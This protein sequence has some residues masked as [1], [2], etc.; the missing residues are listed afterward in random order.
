M[1][2]N[3]EIEVLGNTAPL[4]PI[5]DAPPAE[6]APTEAP[7]ENVQV[8]EAPAQVEIVE[9]APTE[10]APV[11]TPA[12]TTP[13]APVEPAPVETPAEIA[14][15]PAPVMP[16]V[17]P[18]AP[19]ENP[20]PAAPVEPTPTV[21]P[22]ATPAPEEPKKKKGKGGLIIIIILL[23]A[24]AGFAVW[25]FVLGGNGSK[26]EEPKKDE[27][28]E[29]KKEEI[30]ELSDKEKLDAI[31][32]EGSELDIDFNEVQKLYKLVTYGDENSQKEHY[33]PIWKIKENSTLV[34]SELSDEEKVNAIVH[35]L[36]ENEYKEVECE[37]LD[38]PEKSGVLMNECVY[39]KNIIKNET[40]AKQRYYT[41]EYILG[42]YTS[43]YGSKAK[44]NLETPIKPYSTQELKYIEKYGNFYLYVVDGGGLDSGLTESVNKIKKAYSYDDYLI[45]ERETTYKSI[46]N[47][48]SLEENMKV[49][50]QEQLS[51]TTNNKYV[52]E[53]DE[54][55]YRLLGIISKTTK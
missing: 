38:I 42:L 43:I 6:P 32:E 46:V 4:E 17:A 44:M 55:S 24:L 25:Y 28:Q 31:K 47:E 11:E 33:N 39:A 45:I 36:D 8:E 50:L 10:P 30:K 40:G 52:F 54:Q 21:E 27:Q 2:E 37:G 22:A 12:E 5:V 1:E 3:K 29:E 20:T 19:A 13:V 16:E 7:V 26:K 51:K 35:L 53:K 23:L 18:V 9:A 48:E 41:K 14:P 34:A 15:T 49:M